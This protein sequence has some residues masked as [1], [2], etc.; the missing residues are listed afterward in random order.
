[1]VAI[2]NPRQAK[3]WNENYGIGARS[4]AVGNA[5]VTL[6]DIWSTHHNQAGLAGVSSLQA[7]VFYENRFGIKELGLKAASIAMP[8]PGISSGVFGLSFSQF[9]YSLYNDTKIGL[10]YAKQLGK[11]YSVGIQVN[12]LQTQMGED[13]GSAGVITAEAGLIA[14]LITNLYFGVHIFNPTRVKLTEYSIQETIFSERVPTIMRCGLRYKFSEK[15]QLSVE[16]EKDV[17][18][19]PFFK[20]G[21]EYR[22]IEQLYIRGGIATDPG[23][24]S[25]GFGV[26]L[27]KFCID[28][29]ASKHQ[30]LGYSTQINITY[31]FGKSE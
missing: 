25:F 19:D 10:G 14:E 12:Y 21:I 29:A 11:K 4:G 16:T 30:V 26:L 5:S 23:Y 24:N 15:V 1:L 22:A 13:Y 8:V 7:G 3:A 6:S 9:G 17:Q 28:I 31:D 27:N 18:Y 20:A 2:I